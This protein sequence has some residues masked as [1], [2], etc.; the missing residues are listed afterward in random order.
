MASTDLIRCL[1]DQPQAVERRQPT[2]EI[3]CY[4]LDYKLKQPDM[5]LRIHSIVKWS[6]RIVGPRVRFIGWLREH[7][8]ITLWLLSRENFPFKKLAWYWPSILKT[9]AMDLAKSCMKNHHQGH[10]CLEHKYNHSAFL[11]ATKLH[12]NYPLTTIV[13]NNNTKFKEKQN[14]KLV[15]CLLPG[16]QTKLCP[17]PVTLPFLSQEYCKDHDGSGFK[18]CRAFQ[19]LFQS[20]GIN[21]MKCQGR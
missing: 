9:R 20:G 8:V 16:V 15:P 5:T 3:L 21:Q 14:T 12:W 17:S 7:L 11:D 10:T 1:Q 2:S 4:D 6:H 13:S 18:Y 19:R